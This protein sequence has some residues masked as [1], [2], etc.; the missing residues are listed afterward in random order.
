MHHERFALELQQRMKAADLRHARALVLM[1]AAL[2]G[3]CPL[4]FPRIDYDLAASVVGAVGREDVRRFAG[5][6]YADAPHF[7]SKFANDQG[8]V[9]RVRLSTSKDLVSLSDKTSTFISVQWQFCEMP[10]Q[11]VVLG[12][13]R[14]FV[15]G[16]EASW[17]NVKSVS[18]LPDRRGRFGYDVVLYVRGWFMSEET[19]EIEG[20]FDLERE[21]RDVCVQVWLTTKMG[22]YRTNVARITKEEIAT[23]LGTDVHSGTAQP[24]PARRHGKRR[25]RHDSAT[26]DKRRAS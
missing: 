15:D 9:V 7:P 4:V 22:G 3:G 26:P 5:D 18:P 12:D 6:R 11:H 16:A 2:V 23:A 25:Q 24:Q 20:K 19:G 10:D 17:I 1:C 21:P 13:V 8:Q 14:A